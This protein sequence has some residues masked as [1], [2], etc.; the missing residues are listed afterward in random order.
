MATLLETG[1]AFRA[2]NITSPK[3]VVLLFE[4]KIWDRFP[5]IAD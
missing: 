2:L 3:L 4:L 5:G 1:G